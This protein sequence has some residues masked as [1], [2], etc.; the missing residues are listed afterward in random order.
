MGRAAYWACVA[1]SAALAATLAAIPARWHEAEDGGRC[2]LTQMWPLFATVKKVGDGGA[3][4]KLLMYREDKIDEP[5]GRRPVLFIPGNAGTGSQCRSLGHVMAYRR[6]E[7]WLFCV[8]FGEELS[9]FHGG[10]VLRQA[11][12]VDAAVDFLCNHYSLSEV[13]VVAHSMGGVVALARES[14]RCRTRTLVG[15][16]V[17]FAAPAGLAD[18][19]MIE[20]YR[21]VR[22]ALAGRSTGGYAAPPR[23][24]VSYS[25]GVRDVLVPEATSTVGGEG[26]AGML[27]E[28]LAFSQGADV[29]GSSDAAEPVGLLNLRTQDIHAD[30][31]GCDHLSIVWCK[32]VVQA[33]VDD[34][35]A[36][37]GGRGFGVEAGGCEGPVGG[38]GITEIPR[39][40][41]F[42]AYAMYNLR[43]VAEEGE[44][45]ALHAVEVDTVDAVNNGTAANC[46]SRRK[47][48]AGRGTEVWAAR[49][50]SGPAGRLQVHRRRGGAG[51]AVG[52]RIDAEVLMLPSLWRAVHAQAPLHRLLSLAAALVI[53]NHHA[54]LCSRSCCAAWHSAALV[55]V[56]AAAPLPTVAIFFLPAVLRTV[57]HLLSRPWLPHRVAAPLQGTLLIAVAAGAL[58]SAVGSA[59]GTVLHL[60]AGGGGFVADA[61]LLQCIPCIAGFVAA[62]AVALD[63]TTVPAALLLAAALL[64]AL[65]PRCGSPPT[66]VARAVTAVGIAVAYLPP[67]PAPAA[68]LGLAALAAVAAAPQTAEH[69]IKVD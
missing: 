28:W 67:S 56:A 14:R 1:A 10:L 44:R 65:R 18:A 16:A 69:I 55:A 66:G 40:P 50:G 9:A 59:A 53:V 15:L 48:F 21:R 45:E 46:Q 4:Y 37:E 20:A 38:G 30:G 7:A 8:D 63:P 62:R 12:F 42:G 32:Q 5:E 57:S 3:G 31:V 23:R 43:L 19:G 68:A 26:T 39:H 58:H 47:L 64:S 35:V 54:P 17:P 29:E 33:T 22:R 2:V 41:V 24:V 13:D 11:R 51:G 49:E 36:A 60:V 25:G 34:V 6:V 61:L 52:A 27:E